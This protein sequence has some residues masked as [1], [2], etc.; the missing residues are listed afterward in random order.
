MIEVIGI[1][2]YVISLLIVRFRYSVYMVGHNIEKVVSA[3]F[4]LFAPVSLI[5]LICEDVYYTHAKKKY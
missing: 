2:V 5:W 1:I 4:L 3:I